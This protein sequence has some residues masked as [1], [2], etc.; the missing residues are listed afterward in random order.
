MAGHLPPLG[1]LRAFEAV[2]RRLSFTR[3]ADELHVT[4]GA[5]SQQVRQLEE[6][7]GQRLFTRTKRSVALT[8]IGMRMLPDVQAGLETLARAIRSHSSR[9]SDRSLTISVAPSFASKWLLPRLADFTRQNPDIDLRVSATV[10]LADLERDG[11]DLAIRLGRGPYPNVRIEAL[12]GE[13]LTP[14]CAPN[15]MKPKGWLRSPEHLRKHKLIHDTSIPGDG[16]RSSWRRWLDFAGATTVPHH[17]GL[18]F[19]MAELAMQAAIDGAGVV[20]GRT[21]L[22]EADL[23]SGRLVRPFNIVLPLDET[24]YLVFPKNGPLRRESV[25]FREWI[26]GFGRSDM[27][28]SQRRK[29][30]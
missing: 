2:A 6:L 21:V 4:P 5:V 20:L 13:S 10:G 1:S 15:L 17:S 14:L 29:R 12:F 23:A 9:G 19:S 22:A 18:R 24:Y 11:V 16:E 8:E 27:R 25:R 30:A 28:K 3:A 26:M 7:L